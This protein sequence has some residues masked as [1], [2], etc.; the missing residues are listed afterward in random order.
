MSWKVN[1]ANF[2]LTEFSEVQGWFCL[3]PYPGG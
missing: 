2:A 1:S 3:V